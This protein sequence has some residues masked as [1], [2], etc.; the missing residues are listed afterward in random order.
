[1]PEVRGR[2]MPGMDPTWLHMKKFQAGQG[3]LIHPAAASIPLIFP[4][5][6][7]HT[8]SCQTVPLK[9]NLEILVTLP[10][11][12]CQ[13]TTPGGFCLLP[14]SSPATSHSG[15]REQLNNLSP[16]HSTKSSQSLETH[17]PHEIQILVQY[18]N[19]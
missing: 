11:S 2:Q 14:A 3:K 13:C 19:Y 17:V 10:S 16:Q 5:K 12:Q 9:L 4:F 8:P 1:M 7:Y 18:K 6:L 15:N